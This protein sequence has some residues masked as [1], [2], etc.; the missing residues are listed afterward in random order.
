MA[1]QNRGLIED[2]TPSVRGSI[3]VMCAGVVGI[4]YIVGAKHWGLNQV[5][6]TA[7]PVAVMLLYAVLLRTPAFRLRD[8]QSGDNLYYLGFLYTLTSIA[9]SLMEYTTGR[10]ADVIVTN[11]GIAVFTTITGLLLRLTFNQMRGDTADIER[12]TRMELAEAARRMRGEL[13]NAVL[14][15]KQFQRATIQSV[16]GSFTSLRT[17]TEETLKTLVTSA[18]EFSKV[19]T[20]TSKDRDSQLSETTTKLN[21]AMNA[22]AKSFEKIGNQLDLFKSPE[23]LI[24][25]EL[26]S[27][28]ETLEQFVTEMASTQHSFISRIDAQLANS[29]STAASL[30]Q[31]VA[32]TDQL[33]RGAA[34]A[35]FQLAE[36]LSRLE[37]WAAGDRTMP[38]P[39]SRTWWKPF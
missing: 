4:G 23:T 24:K 26:G 38:D 21:K 3:A 17:L 33:M 32:S 27:A 9:V 39:R 10:D 25:L 2:G 29:S 13:D 22:A 19:S 36:R 31:L 34:E 11:F 5:L 28:K 8:D 7:G 16:E 18:E 6:V 30:Q 14:E 12:V 1:N 35:Q 15:L 37:Q 20:S